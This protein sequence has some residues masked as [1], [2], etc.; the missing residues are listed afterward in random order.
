M[1][2]PQHH[3]LGEAV[4]LGTAARQGGYTEPDSRPYSG[5][6]CAAIGCASILVFQRAGRVSSSPMSI[7][8]RFR[9]RHATRFRS[10]IRIMSHAASCASN[11]MATS[12]LT[13]WLPYPTTGA[14]TGCASCSARESSPAGRNQLFAGR[15]RPIQPLKAAIASGTAPPRINTRSPGR[16]IHSIMRERLLPI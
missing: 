2:I 3:G 8:M 9:L 14:H 6:S 11:S 1:F 10:K 5:F 13:A 7:E 15:C 4:G 16:R 12:W